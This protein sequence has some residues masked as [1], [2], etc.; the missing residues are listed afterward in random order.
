MY[1]VPVTN[2]I[3]S[4]KKDDQMKYSLLVSAR[5]SIYK[6]WKIRSTKFPNHRNLSQRF[7]NG[8]VYIF[9]CVA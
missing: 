7:D 9:Y 4:L 2:T 5:L 1:I 8:V 6:P 3:W